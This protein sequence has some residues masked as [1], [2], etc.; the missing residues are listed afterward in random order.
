[1]TGEPLD[2]ATIAR[3]QDVVRLCRLAEA[4][5]DRGREWYDSDPEL[6]APKL[7]ADSVVLKMG[8]AVR[9]LPAGFLT[10]REDDPTWRRAVGMRHRIAHEY[11]AVD[12]EIVWTVIA[13]HAGELERRVHDAIALGAPATP[14]EGR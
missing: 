14:P 11:D 4:L 7:A 1:M 2:R 13:T 12:Y 8:E 3:L 10:E 9:R 6:N 5:A